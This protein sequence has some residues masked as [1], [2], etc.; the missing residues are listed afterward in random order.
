MASD[1]MLPIFT[2]QQPSEGDQLNP[3]TMYDYKIMDL[4][5]AT[6]IVP[7]D[8]H[9]NA[10]PLFI[11]IKNIL[12]RSTQI[13]GNVLLVYIYIYASTII[14]LLQKILFTFFFSLIF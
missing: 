9:F 1:K 7:P 10:E 8:E 11:V 3:F 13:V 14:Y 12:R 2:A 5:S 4:I 6:H